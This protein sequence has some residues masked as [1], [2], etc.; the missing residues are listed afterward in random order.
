MLRFEKA[1]EQIDNN[2]V[3]NLRFKMLS[4]ILC[5]HKTTYGQVTTSSRSFVYMLTILSGFTSF[6][7]SVL[8]ALFT[9]NNY[10]IRLANYAWVYPYHPISYPYHGRVPFVRVGAQKPGVS[11]EKKDF[12]YDYCHEASA[13]SPLNQFELLS[14]FS[15]A[16]SCFSDDYFYYRRLWLKNEITILHSLLLELIKTFIT[17]AKV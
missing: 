12:N 5:K 13:K 7:L 2:I 9:L 3:K 10:A 15:P 16:S 14:I 4:L 1:K 8:V 17:R 6:K 11:S